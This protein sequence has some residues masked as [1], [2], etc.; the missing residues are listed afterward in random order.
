MAFNEINKSSKFEKS[1]SES[2]LRTIIRQY[3]IPEEEYFAFTKR[4]IG[5]KTQNRQNTEGNSN[6]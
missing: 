2:L 4:F 3:G 1:N 5:K 6:S